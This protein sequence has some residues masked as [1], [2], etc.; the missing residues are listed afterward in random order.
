MKIALH[1]GVLYVIYIMGTWVQRVFDLF[2]PGSVIGLILL[3]ILLMTGIIKAPWVENGARFFIKHLALFFIPATVGVINYLDL[4]SGEGLL[5]V[6]IGLVS[7][8]MVMV[9]AGHVSQ[10]LIERKERSH[11]HE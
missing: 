4:F 1:I 9:S 7:T 3:F 2:I 5:L 6:V 11:S 10:L 8:L